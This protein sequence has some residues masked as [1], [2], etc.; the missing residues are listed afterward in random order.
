MKLSS[1]HRQRLLT[2]LALGI[3]GLW[4][5]DTLVL[6]PSLQAWQRR[7]TRLAELRKNIAQ[8]RQLI[9]RETSLRERWDSMRTHTL[10]SGVSAAEGQVLSRF[11][12]WS[13]ES[14]MSITSVTP[15]RKRG[16]EDGYLTL[17]CRVDGFGSMAAVTRF[18]YEI[19]RDPI[20]LR[21]DAVELASRDPDGAQITL[22]LQVSGLILES[23]EP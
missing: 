20:A 6:G 2:F 23:S 9:E 3:V 15:Q 12:R 10:A 5:A 11:D 19:E 14:R 1:Q 17:E 7:S 8:G 16:A 21:V 13:Q 4:A 22:G 18:L